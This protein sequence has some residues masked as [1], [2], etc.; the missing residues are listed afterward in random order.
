M[1]SEH[2]WNSEPIESWAKNKALE[3]A[4][5]VVVDNVK[6]EEKKM[7]EM[8]D[9]KKKVE[10]LLAK[11]PA[12]K[13]RFDKVSLKW[14]KTI[15]H[16]NTY[17]IFLKEKIE[18]MDDEA[19]KQL[20]EEKLNSLYK[21]WNKV[22][23]ENLKKW[24]TLENIEAFSVNYQ[25]YFIWKWKESQ[26]NAF[27][28]KFESV[29]S[30]KDTLENA[31]DLFY[32]YSLREIVWELILTEDFKT[33]E[34][35][36]KIQLLA[37]LFTKHNRSFEIKVDGLWWRQTSTFFRIL[38]RDKVFLGSTNWQLYAEKIKKILSG[39]K[40][41]AEDVSLYGSFSDAAARM[42]QYTKDP[43]NYWKEKSVIWNH[44]ISAEAS[45]TSYPSVDSMSK[46]DS[47]FITSNR[48]S[49]LDWDLAD[50]F[51]MRWKT[52]EQVKEIKERLQSLLPK[53]DLKKHLTEFLKNEK[54]RKE[55]S[56]L[57]KLPAST[58]DD[59]LLVETIINDK[60]SDPKFKNIRDWI[61]SGM[62]A[63]VGTDLV[64][65]SIDLQSYIRKQCGL[66]A[67]SV[68]T[69]FLESVFSDWTTFEPVDRK[70]KKDP[71]DLDYPVYFRDK[72]NPSMIYEYRPNTWDIFAEKY[73][74]YSDWALVFGKWREAGSSMK[75]H[76][77][78]VKFSDFMHNIS[79]LDLLPSKRAETRLQLKDQIAWNV[80]SKMD[81]TV[82]SDESATIRDNNNL[83]R[84]RNWII[85]STLSMFW[86]AEASKDS[87][88]IEWWIRLTEDEN[89][90]YY[91]LMSRLVNTV[92]WASESDL[93]VLNDFL[94][95]LS[96]KIKNID[97]VDLKSVTNPLIRF[98]L[99]EQKWLNSYW[100]DKIKVDNK[101]EEWKKKDFLLWTLMDSLFVGGK[102]NFDKL[103]VLNGEGSN[104]KYAEIASKIESEYNEKAK[105]YEISVLSQMTGENLQALQRDVAVGEEYTWRIEEAYS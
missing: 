86:I 66:S 14:L 72:N 69:K 83:M 39:H 23:L 37:W 48:S 18:P 12:L 77:M 54:V 67:L 31:V 27:I 10:V 76:T 36:K 33:P 11:S 38:L 3:A 87:W 93:K 17:Q 35:L 88:N 80:E 103:R 53:E 70:E 16:V 40:Q 2:L 15:S 102:M 61:T 56:E 57:F 32:D 94:V 60:S 1:S 55:F 21:D 5:S 62:W 95:D 92:E 34:S 7:N 29:S 44:F 50:L 19:V 9:L 71:S 4:A 13:V 65:L 45:K 52:S 104:S 63:S 98:V 84:L 51:D 30:D 101:L 105:Q 26:T 79:V 41:Y 20:T 68:K 6:V 82:Q 74:G 100:E 97:N 99:S 43:V 25:K 28:K 24:L 42:E 78:K 47:E 58:L 46:I 96:E 90:P 91:N 75:I 89:G 59:S 85:N 73:Y 22:R 49:S 81:Y 64:S 8:E